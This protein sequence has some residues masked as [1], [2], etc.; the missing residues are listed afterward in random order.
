MT[1]L[2]KAL[3]VSELNKNHLCGFKDRFYAA[4]SALGLKKF[5]RTRFF[6][7]VS[8]LSWSG[9]KVCLEDDRPPKKVIAL[10]SMSTDLS[11]RINKKLMVN[12]TSQDMERYLVT[13]SGPYKNILHEFLSSD[14]DRRK[15]WD[16]S[17][18]RP[19]VNGRVVLLMG[20]VAN[21]MGIELTTDIETEQ[22][23]IMNRKLTVYCNEH[24]ELDTL[25]SNDSFLELVKSMINVAHAKLQ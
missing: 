8:G 7:D 4:C 22:F 23:E 21:D 1:V 17:T 13:G 9:A 5:G 18:V 10:R 19:A 12:H 6:T 25:E 20:K 11:R 15:K 14:E 16:I 3:Q 2:D 24:I